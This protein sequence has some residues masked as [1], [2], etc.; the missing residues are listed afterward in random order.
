MNN[1]VIQ[2]IIFI[3]IT[4]IPLFIKGLIQIYS[5]YKYNCKELIKQGVGNLLFA[6]CPCANHLYLGIIL[7]FTIPIE[8]N[9]WYESKFN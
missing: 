2:I 7:L 5:G 6:F 9:N 4:F 8:I 1:P 3:S